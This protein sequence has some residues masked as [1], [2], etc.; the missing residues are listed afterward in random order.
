M[1]LIYAK[2]EQGR[3]A[4]R[5]RGAL[6][7]R[8]RQIT[9]LCNGARSHQDL[10]QLFGEAAAAQLADLTARGFLQA[11]DSSRSHAQQLAATGRRPAVA[12]A[13]RQAALAP[14]GSDFVLSQ[15]DR[16]PPGPL[17]GEL[18]PLG[19]SDFAALTGSARPPAAPAP[20]ASAAPAAMP[21]SLAA[22]LN[23]AARQTV[24][25]RSIM[26][27]KNF[28]TQVLLTLGQ[29]AALQLVNTYGDVRHEADILLYLAQGMG[30]LHTE[31]GRQTVLQVAQ[32]LI[33]RLP[34]TA[35]PLWLDCTLD[36]VP[37]DIGVELYELALADCDSLPAHTSP[38][39]A[40]SPSSG[41]ATA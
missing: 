12:D 27:A 33:Q 34:E 18:P 37:A 16:L 23:K 13:M 17:P 38:A 29:P 25:Q 8:E 28:L 32:R 24:P 11:G 26:A 6:S 20:A 1:A 41:S 36:N 4:L 5:Q 3:Q 7:L 31:M 2:I 15:I 21:P 35:W 40:G 30:Y 22:T 9:L 39:G 10:L 14:H 19:N